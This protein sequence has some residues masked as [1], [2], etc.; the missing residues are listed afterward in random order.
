MS[1]GTLP[2]TGDTTSNARV[3][4]ELHG[5]NLEHTPDENGP[6][7]FQATISEHGAHALVA[8]ELVKETQEW[9]VYVDDGE[10]TLNVEQA[11]AFSR[12]IETAVK[13]CKALN[14]PIPSTDG[15]NTLLIPSGWLSIKRGL[16]T[17]YPMDIARYSD[18]SGQ[19][20]YVMATNWRDAWRIKG[21]TWEWSIGSGRKATVYEYIGTWEL[22]TFNADGSVLI[23]EVAR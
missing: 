19:L 3:T 7:I 15:R 6:G 20:D 1:T 2:I 11:Q 22:V 16:E 13:I 9:G 5:F 23:V 4:L 18:K 12:N 10:G 14:R 21:D 17:G 8:V